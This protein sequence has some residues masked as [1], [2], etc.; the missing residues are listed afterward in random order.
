MRPSQ[1]SERWMA[2]QCP[3]CR[4][5][6]I[7]FENAP[8]DGKVD[9]DPFPDRPK[10]YVRPSWVLTCPGCGSPDRPV[11]MR[12]RI[13]ERNAFHLRGP[14]PVFGARRLVQL[15]SPYAGDV[16]LHLR[17]LRACLRDSLTRNEAPF[18]SH[19][20]YT[21]PGVLDDTDLAERE[22]GIKAGLAW[23]EAVDYVVAYVDLGFS[24]GMLEGLL[25]ADRLGVPMVYRRLGG[26]K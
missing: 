2:T 8:D 4:R 15:E 7:R 9:G 19:G 17:Y 20:L 3:G 1:L 6:A 22:L 12:E 13:G 11:E 14:L 16:E 21:Q 26:W 25:E 10:F 18:A 23:I 24:R 5:S